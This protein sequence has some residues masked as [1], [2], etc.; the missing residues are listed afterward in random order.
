MCKLSILLLLVVLFTGWIPRVI[1][2]L[3]AVSTTG[4]AIDNIN[5]ENI[6]CLY[7]NATMNLRGSISMKQ[8]FAAQATGS[9]INMNMYIV[10]GYPGP[11]SGTKDTKATSYPMAWPYGIAADSTGGYFASLADGNLVVY[12]SSDLFSTACGYSGHVSVENLEYFLFIF[13]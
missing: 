1:A 6:I 5:N 11:I 8:V 3:D 2:N 7:E 10:G 9:C 12:V 4:A 13:K